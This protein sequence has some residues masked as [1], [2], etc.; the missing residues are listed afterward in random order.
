MFH[1]CD[2]SRGK[3]ICLWCM[4]YAVHPALPPGQTQEGA[5]WRE[6]VPVWS[7]SSGQC[8]VFLDTADRLNMYLIFILHLVCCRAWSK[9]VFC[10]CFFASLTELFADRQAAETQTAVYSWSEQRRKPILPERNSPYSFLESPPTLQQPS[11]TVWAGT[12]QHQSAV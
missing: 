2:A 1:T 11:L 8:V 9:P 10:C 4:W 6:A 5:Q 7:M 12:P 3:T